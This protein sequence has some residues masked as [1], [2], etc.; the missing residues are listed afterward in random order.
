MG[1]GFINL[2]FV[3]VFIAYGYA[4]APNALD[5]D[6]IKKTLED[7]PTLS[8]VQKQLDESGIV[9]P[10]VPN[11]NI[12]PEKVEKV[13]RDKCESQNATDAVEHLKGQQEIIKECVTL[14]L[15]GSEIEAELTEA[16]K[17]GSMDEVFT[18]YCKKWPDIYNCFDNAT[19]TIRQCLTEQEDKSFNKTLDIIQEMQEFMCFK[20][21]DRLALF[22]AEGGVDCLKEKQ[23]GISR[24]FNS[25]FHDRV[26]DTN[27]LS[28]ASLPLLLFQPKDC[29]DFEVLRNCIKD[30]L[31]TCKDTTPANIMDATF[32]FIKKQMIC[33]ENSSKPVVRADAV[34]GGAFHSLGSSVLIFVTFVALFRL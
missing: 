31:E 7:S 1:F 2:I 10:E 30:Q 16:K 26:P 21:G 33:N 4:Q 24:C 13:L 15:N 18:K 12:D 25:T 3:F 11:A 32:K 23:E 6:D 19:A 34:T 5:F 8:D 29:D 22:V 17:T 27:D 20:D 14:Y 9:L 28:A